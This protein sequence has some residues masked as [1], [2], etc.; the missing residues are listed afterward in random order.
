MPIASMDPSYIWCKPRW[1]R[2]LK[3]AFGQI[4]SCKA[5]CVQ[6]FSMNILLTIILCLVTA[7]ENLKYLKDAVASAQNS[8]GDE[9]RHMTLMSCLV[10]LSLLVAPQPIMKHYLPFA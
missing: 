8:I 5:I 2:Q 1:V 7:E 6:A 3:I 4:R 9:K 10:I